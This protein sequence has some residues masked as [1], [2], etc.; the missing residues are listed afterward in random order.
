MISLLSIKKQKKV[1]IFSGFYCAFL[2]N[3]WFKCILLLGDAPGTM[4]AIG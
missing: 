4:G 2:S 3:A 1:S